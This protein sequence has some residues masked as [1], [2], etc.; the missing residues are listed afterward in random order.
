MQS[1]AEV[2][3]DRAINLLSTRKEGLSEEEAKGRLA[4]VVRTKRKKKDGFFFK[5]LAQFKD[6]MILVLLV[7][8][9][10][11]VVIG[12]AQGTTSEVVDGIIIL[13]IVLVNSIFGVL[14]ERKA[15]KSLK[16][17]E[18]MSSPEIFVIRKG[19]IKKID[20]QN[21]AKGDVFLL[22]DR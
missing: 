7:A 5:L 18:K 8:S 22:E 9:F 12:F 13:A 16:L 15:E 14:Q 11:S 10:V 6:L 19:E 1:V 20:V 17:L 21:V 4:S 3:I 2:S